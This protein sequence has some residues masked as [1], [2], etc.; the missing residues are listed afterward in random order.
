MSKK[1]PSSGVSPSGPMLG[2]ESEPDG[3]A[4]APLA[5]AIVELAIQMW[6]EEKREKDDQ[7]EAA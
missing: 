1:V 4:L 6:R 3:A 5:R 2:T 7:R